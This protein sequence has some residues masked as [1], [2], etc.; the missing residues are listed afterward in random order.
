MSSA[1]A[2]ALLAQGRFDALDF[3]CGHGSSVEFI[4]KKLGFERVL[5]IDSD[6]RRVAIACQGGIEAI[7]GNAVDLDA[8]AKCLEAS[9]MFHFLEHLE[10]LD[11]AKKVL[12]TACRASRAFILIRQP[13]FGADEF[14]FK[15]GLK[16]AWS[17]WCAHTN[18]MTTL[19]FW[20][21]LTDLQRGG[22]LHDFFISYAIPI[23]SSLDSQVLPLSAD[24]DALFY[25]VAQGGKPSIC[26]EGVYR[27]VAVLIRLHSGVD[28]DP[29]EQASRVARRVY[30]LET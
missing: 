22:D 16:L 7:H 23:E 29:I 8:P 4:N 15:L 11:C 24:N 21:I 2:A 3:G 6:E 10:S 5:G 14:L 20:A 1:D 12:S 9:F 25:D 13:F 26:L 28:V 18:R 19:D 27:E 17:T 30:P